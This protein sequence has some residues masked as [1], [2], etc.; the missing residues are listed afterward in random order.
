MA[1]YF[2]MRL[3]CVVCVVFGVIHITLNTP[4]AL[5]ERR[6]GLSTNVSA[7]RSRFSSTRGTTQRSPS[8]VE[9]RGAAIDV[10]HV[11]QRKR[12]PRVLRS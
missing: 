4:V 3:L 7:F 9:K 10:L 6:S 11:E 8:V 2:S 5:A 12:S 1:V